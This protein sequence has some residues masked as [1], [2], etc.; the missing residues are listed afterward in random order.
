MRSMLLHGQDEDWL[1]ACMI[2]RCHAFDSA[3]GYSPVQSHIL[4]CCEGQDPAAARMLLNAGRVI[5]QCCHVH[6]PGDPLV[7]KKQKPKGMKEESHGG[8]L[9]RAGQGKDADC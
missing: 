1:L 9:H 2:T 3:A 7:G 5:W 4:V 8:A 6:I